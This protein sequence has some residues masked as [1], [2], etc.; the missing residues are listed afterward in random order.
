LFETNKSKAKGQAWPVLHVATL[1]FCR[2]GL[3]APVKRCFI[4]DVL[5]SELPNVVV[6]LQSGVALLYKAIS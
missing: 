5:T 2:Q 3:Y 4:V 1:P 6:M